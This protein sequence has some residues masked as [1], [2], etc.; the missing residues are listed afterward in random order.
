MMTLQDSS[1]ETSNL[2]LGVISGMRV[3]RGENSWFTHL[4]FGRVLNRLADHFAHVVYMAKEITEQSPAMDSELNPQKIEVAPGPSYHHSINALRHPLRFW[5]GYRS[6]VEQCDVVFIR[7]MVPFSWFIHF[8]CWRR[9]RPVSHWLV[10]NPVELLKMESRFGG[11]KDKLALWYCMFDETTLGAAARLSRAALVVNGQEL[12]EKWRKLSPMTVV[13]STIS[14]DEFKERDDTC[15]AT[16]VR[17]LFVGF[18]RPEKGL[19]YLVRALRLVNDCAPANLHIVGPR[20]GFPEEVRRIE[21]VIDELGLKDMVHWENYASFGDALFGHLDA[22]D[23]LALP[24]LSEGTP[25]VLVEARARCLPVVSTTVGGIPSSVT[26][27]EDGLLVPAKD[28][29]SLSKALL[30]LIHDSTLRQKIIR[31]GHARAKALCVE[32][33]TDQLFGGIQ[34]AIARRSRK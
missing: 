30:R 28:S 13:S 9:R 3:Y 2:T 21:S 34:E 5:R 24:S 25:R 14:L 29:A 27:G 17:I 7:G 19:E 12:S 10:G 26:D 23:I 31:Q 6:L 22:A 16:P 32:R 33:F 20:D 18:I 4:S 11:M 1:T 8:H 15:Q